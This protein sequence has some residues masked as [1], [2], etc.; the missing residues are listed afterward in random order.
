[1]A[2]T[3]K[4]KRKK[5]EL[6]DIP[7]PHSHPPPPKMKN[8]VLY[9]RFWVAAIGVIVVSVGI[10]FGICNLKRGW[11]KSKKKQQRREDGQWHM[12]FWKKNP[13]WGYLCPCLTDFCDSVSNLTMTEGKTPK[14]WHLTI[15]QSPFVPVQSETIYIYNIHTILYIYIKKHYM[16]IQNNPLKTTVWIRITLQQKLHTGKL[17]WCVMA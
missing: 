14:N 10:F 16:C 1:M 8:Q 2:Q 15:R 9:E 7:L 6:F 4:E 11:E 17:S 5:E 3:F 12:A 13:F